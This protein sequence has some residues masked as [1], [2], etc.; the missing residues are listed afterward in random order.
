MH[1]DVLSLLIG[2]GV[3]IGIA[4]FAVVFRTHGL[5]RPYHVIYRALPRWRRER[6]H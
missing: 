1:L 2:I 3:G 4:L 6:R 5:G